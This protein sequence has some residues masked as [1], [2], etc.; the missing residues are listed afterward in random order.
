MKKMIKVLLTSAMIGAVSLTTFFS[1]ANQP[2]VSAAQG[3]WSLAGHSWPASTRTNITYSRDGSADA[4]WNNA[5]NNWNYKTNL[6]KFTNGGTSGK[7]SLSTVYNSSI[8]SDGRATTYFDASKNAYGGFSWLNTYHTSKYTAAKT[9]SVATHELGHIL[10]LAD[11]SSGYASLMNGYT[12]ARYDTF[13]IYTPQ[14]DDVD[15]ITFIY[16]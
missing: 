5:V 16:K 10:G 4:V 15:G 1:F 2:V 11:L 12:S 6:I 13:G 7:V 14:K 8:D 9:E 3:G